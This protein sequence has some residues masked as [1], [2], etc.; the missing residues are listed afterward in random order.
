MANESKDEVYKDEGGKNQAPAAALKV[1]LIATASAL[2]GGLAVAWWY[3]E[4]LKKLQNPVNSKNLPKNGY[5][6]EVSPDADQDLFDNSEPGT[7]PPPI[8]D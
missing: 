4:T 7:L 5:F 1:G 3:R 6:E 2:A 8:R